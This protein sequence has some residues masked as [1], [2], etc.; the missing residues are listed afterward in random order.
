MS[1]Q[2]FEVSVIPRRRAHL[3]RSILFQRTICAVFSQ[4][5]QPS[6]PV[7]IALLQVLKHA[8][9][10]SFLLNSL[11]TSNAYSEIHYFFFANLLEGCGFRPTA[12]IIGLSLV[13]SN[14]P[15]QLRSES[16]DPDGE[17]YEETEV[18]QHVDI[19]EIQ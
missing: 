5:S 1:E 13:S 6:L 4:L 18:P 15:L 8:E 11:G 14:C 12:I 3:K 10:H 7:Q 19:R 17:L 9:S 16:Y 2:L